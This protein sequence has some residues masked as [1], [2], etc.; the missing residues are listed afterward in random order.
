VVALQSSAHNQ[1]M[2][3]AG[4][5]F[6]LCLSASSYNYCRHGS[7]S[8][9]PRRHTTPLL[10]GV[11]SSSSSRSLGPR[12]EDRIKSV[13]SAQS[14]GMEGQ[15][16]DG[17]SSLRFMGWEKRYF[18]LKRFQEREGH[19]N[20]TK[21]H[22]ED[23]I[24]LGKWVG[25]QHRLK[26][27]GELDQERQILLEE[28]D[29]VWV[30]SKPHVPW[31][32][33]FDQLKQFKT[34]EGHCNVPHSHKEEGANL[35]MWV[36]T[37]RRLKKK[38]KLDPDRQK[39]L[40]D[41][42][43]EWNLVDHSASVPWEE[44]FDLLKQFKKREGHCNV[45]NLHKEDGTTL[46]F[47]VDRQRQLKRMEKLDP[48][49][50]EMLEDIGFEWVLFERRAN[51]PWE[52]IFSLLEEFKKREGHCNV[53]QL[54]KEDGNKLGVWVNAQRQHKKKEKLGPDRQKMLEDIG[55]EWAGRQKA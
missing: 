43:F 41:I 5:L 23:G 32:E 11:E 21:S 51:V 16:D 33:R 28:I 8:D 34:R 15:V 3:A 29:I 55:F 18:L 12:R 38:E 27:L 6:L 4:S 30:L 22:T 25:R 46:G 20:V 17:V 37:Q 44:R 48:D 54:H 52:E 53:P 31:K 42:G 40:E 45:P 14:A 2:V 19:C 26:R 50:Q 7:S 1:T 13:L 39:M 47:W 24:K 36:N 10:F 49:R 35:G 9:V